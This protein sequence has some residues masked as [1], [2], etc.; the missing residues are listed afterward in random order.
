MTTPKKSVL[1]QEQRDAVAKANAE[2]STSKRGK[3]YVRSFKLAVP[4]ERLE[5]LPMQPQRLSFCK[6]VAIAC[7]THKTEWAT[8]KQVIEVLMDPKGGSW[9]RMPTRID[10][11]VDGIGTPAHV[12]AVTGVISFYD[13]AEFREVRVNDKDIPLFE[14]R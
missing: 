3:A 2:A 9:L 5:L 8:A 12:K 11:D 13:Q 7:K 4:A 10:H 1:T 6:A 14:S